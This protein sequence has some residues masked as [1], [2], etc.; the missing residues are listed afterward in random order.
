MARYTGPTCRLCRREG[1][2]LYLK[3]ERCYSARC[4]V[5]RRNYAPGQHGQRRGRKLSTYGTQLREKQRAKRMYGILEHQFRRY[6]RIA[7]RYRGATGVVL[8]QML[9]RRLDNIVYRI[10][11]ASTRSATRQLVRHGHI[12]VNGKRVDIPSYSVSPG[13][14][15]ALVEKMRKSGGVQGSLE[16]T[17]K[18]GRVPW[19]EYNAEK[20]TG[21]LLGIPERGDIPVDIQEQMIV[22]LYSK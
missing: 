10:G 8:M 4:A 20:F 9:E 19:L 11:F 7:D 16:K 12:L 22:E 17:E 18:S 1:K 21:R 6:F 5:E 13:E 3:G 2:K 14:E 15:I